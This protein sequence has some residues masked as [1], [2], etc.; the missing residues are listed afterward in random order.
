MQRCQEGFEH[1]KLRDL[2]ASGCWKLSEKVR[3]GE[4]M[5]GKLSCSCF[6]SELRRRGR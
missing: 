3:G 2:L 5:T 1:W 4:Y 6:C